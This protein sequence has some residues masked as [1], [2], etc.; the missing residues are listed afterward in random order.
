MSCRDA[1]VYLVRQPRNDLSVLISRQ[2]RS[3]LLIVARAS[4]LSTLGLYGLSSL[5]KDIG[6]FWSNTSYRCEYKRCKGTTFHNLYSSHVASFLGILVV[7]I[8][9]G[10]LQLEVGWRHWV[11]LGKKLK[12]ITITIKLYRHTRGYQ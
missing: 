5:S 11:F 1:V 6:H 7:L 12:I 4:P 10:N 9:R 8:Q 3:F 2:N